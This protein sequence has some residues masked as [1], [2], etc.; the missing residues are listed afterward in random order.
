M[1]GLWFVFCGLGFVGSMCLGF[2][3]VRLVVG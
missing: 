1:F 2:V 3:C